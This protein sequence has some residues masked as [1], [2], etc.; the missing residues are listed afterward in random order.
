MADM[1]WRGSGRWGCSWGSRESVRAA[2]DTRACR[3]KDPAR[4]RGRDYRRSLGQVIRPG[5][6]AMAR[7]TR[8]V[9][10]GLV[11]AGGATELA[12]TPRI[13]IVRIVDCRS[14]KLKVDPV[15][16]VCRETRSSSPGGGS[17]SRQRRITTCHLSRHRRE[18]LG[19]PLPRPV[20]RPLPLCHVRHLS[21]RH[22][23]ADPSAATKYPGYRPVLSL[24]AQ[25]DL[26]TRLCQPQ[27][28]RYFEWKAHLPAM[29]GVR[30][31]SRSR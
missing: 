18:P 23:G 26:S 3:R 5:R 29:F 28:G 12:A 19:A 24:E 30:R 10:D 21:L 9:L 8:T 2:S 15:A 6:Y 27:P 13:A 20:R 17:R 31:L 11:L 1:F 7:D 4:G 16:A 25:P 14:Q 22:Q